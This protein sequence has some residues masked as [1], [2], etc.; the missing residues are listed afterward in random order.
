MSFRTH[1]QNLQVAEN[2]SPEVI[3][4]AYRYLSQK[5]HPDKNTNDPELAARNMRLINAAYEV[6]S[7]PVRRQKHDEWIKEQRDSF[8]SQRTAEETEQEDS[9]AK[10]SPP[11]SGNE[12][13]TG[14]ASINTSDSINH[15]WAWA[16]SIVPIFLLLAVTFLPPIESEGFYTFASIGAYVLFCYLDERNLKKSGYAAPNTFWVFFVPVYLWQRDTP[17]GKWHPRFITWCAALLVSIFLYSDPY[18]IGEELSGV[19]TN[20]DLGNIELVLG[21]DPKTI[22]IGQD[23]MRVKYLKSDGDRT[24]YE[25][26]SG[27]W[28]GNKVTVRQIWESEGGFTLELIFFDDPNETYDLGYLRPN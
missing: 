11:P 1:Y 15:E 10:N 8:S 21:T 22:S 20:S 23:K 9:A 12:K 19:W 27:E 16:A 25:F 14:G 6:L 7:D 4:G 26:I 18:T 5:W 17:F 24:V 28:K 13:S 3:R 2:A